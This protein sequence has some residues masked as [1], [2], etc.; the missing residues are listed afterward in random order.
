[1]I[2]LN[3]II[4]IMDISNKVFLWNKSKIWIVIVVKLLIK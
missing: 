3:Q 4:L 1:M 2:I